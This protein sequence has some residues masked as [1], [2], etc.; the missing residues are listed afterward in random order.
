[1]T[2]P[3]KMG[4][5]IET[6]R[7]NEYFSKMI[8]DI[9]MSLVKQEDD[10]LRDVLMDEMMRLKAMERIAMMRLLLTDLLDTMDSYIIE[11]NNLQFEQ[12]T[13]K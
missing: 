7:N 1:M 9:K 12:E 10:L 8:E 4:L 5:E 13:H 6:L 3:I 2:D 11:A